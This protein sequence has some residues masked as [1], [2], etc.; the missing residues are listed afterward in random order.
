MKVPFLAATALLALA[1]APAHAQAWDFTITVPVNVSGVP[2]NVTE[3]SIACDVRPEDY[4][5][6]RNQIA[7]GV[8][9]QTLTGGAFHGNVI[10]HAN[11][12]AGRNASLGRWYQCRASFHGTERGIMVTYFLSGPTTPPIF[13]VAAGAPLNLGDQTHWIRI[14]GVAH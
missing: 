7:H 9:N 6:G 14:P 10:V 4:G 1:A 12:A 13:P 2:A 11:A 8:Q 3:I 5:D